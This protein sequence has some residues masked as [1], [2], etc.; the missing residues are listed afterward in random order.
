M[1]TTTSTPASSA[2]PLLIDLLREEILNGLPVRFVAG[3]V[4]Q[5]SRWEELSLQD[6]I[7]YRLSALAQYGEAQ[8][9]KERSSHIPFYAQR[10]AKTG[11]DQVWLRLAGSYE[12]DW[13]GRD[14]PLLDLVPSFPESS[15][16]AGATDSASSPRSPAQ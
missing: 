10:A 8:R 15:T 13:T 2:G 9:C 16:L 5:P 11:D 6:R 14:K 3:W 12:G 4:I 1:P 7:R